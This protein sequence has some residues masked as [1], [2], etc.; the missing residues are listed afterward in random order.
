L[1]GFGGSS[2][3][4]PVDGVVGEP[5][6]VHA[7]KPAA[8]G[9]L[10]RSWSIPAESAVHVGDGLADARLFPFVGGSVALNATD[11]AVIRAAD[12]SLSSSSL[13]DL[14]PLL[15]RLRPHPPVRAPPVGL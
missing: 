8:L 9:R 14:L 11:P 5:D 3:R 2:S 1:D 13:L 6:P 7:D 15:E 4:E 10:L 12:A